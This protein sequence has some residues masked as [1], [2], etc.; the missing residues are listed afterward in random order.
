[1]ATE[2]KVPA[3]GESIT[4]GIIAA[5]NVKDGDYVQRDQAIYELETDKIT[6]EGLAEV[7]GRISLKAAEGDEVEIG[8]AIA[9]IDET[10]TAP[11]NSKAE[12]PGKTESIC[13]TANSD[14]VSPAVRHIASEQDLDLQNVDGTGNAGRVTKGDMLAALESPTKTSDSPSATPT[15]TPAASA[16]KRARS[17][18]KRMTPLRRKIAERLVSAQ[19]ETAMLTT[20]NEIDLTAI[21]AIR[22]K[23]QEAFVEK[24]GIKLGFMSFFVKAVVR[25]LQEVPAVNTMLEGDEIVQN[26]Y[27]DIGIA[28]STKKGLIVPVVRD[29]EQLGL[30][31]IEK[32][33]INYAGKARDGKIALDDIQG[34]VFTITNGGIFGSMLSTPILNPPQ[35]AILGMHAIQ[36]RPIAVNGEV[37]VRPMMYLALSYDHRIIDGKEAVTFLA[38]VKQLLEVPYRLLLEI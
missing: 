18:R 5:W 19:Q 30:V 36:D 3:L 22:S 33:I 26:N 9:E 32:E 27:F 6:S 2:I 34:G 11:E 15:E 35:S 16:L 37:V 1:M 17:T 23:H 14:A 21:K 25:A 7:A 31:G 24:H 38:Q 10:A 29:C 8:Q 12:T 20:F 4:S 13:E 28:V